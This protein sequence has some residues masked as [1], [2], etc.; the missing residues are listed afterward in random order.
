MSREFPD[1]V[2]PWKAADGRRTFQGTM[3]LKWMKRLS[4]LLA[5]VDQGADPGAEWPDARFSATFGHDREGTVTVNIEV[6]AAL[7]LVCQRSLETY[8]E[9]VSR[10]SELAVLESLEAQDLVPEHY[11]PVLAEHGRLALLDLVEDELLLA[12][13]QVPR[14]PE[15]RAIR[16]STDAG[17]QIVD[18]G[19]DDSGEEAERTHRPFENLAELL[20]KGRK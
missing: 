15:L 12:V 9:Q 2:D 4:P 3:P 16:H 17:A 5:P 11:E 18:E 6:E 19:G 13:P 20:E 1:W 10:H 14:N 7:P 8:L